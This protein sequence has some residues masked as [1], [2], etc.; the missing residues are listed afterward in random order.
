MRARLTR[1]VSAEDFAQGQFIK[2]I[3][4]FETSAKFKRI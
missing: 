3:N 1:K 2:V 4:V